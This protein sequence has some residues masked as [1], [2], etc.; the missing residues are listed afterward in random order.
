MDGTELRRRLA[1]HGLSHL[2]R[3]EPEGERASTRSVAN[4]TSFTDSSLTNATTYYYKV[5]AENSNGEGPLSSEASATPTDLVPPAEPLPLVDSFDRANENPLSDAGRWSNGVIGAAETGLHVT[6]NQLAC[7]RTTTCT[8]WRNGAQYGPDAESW[9]RLATLP[10]TSN[11]LR[12]Y[13]R[14]SQAG[15]GGSAYMLRTIQQTGVDQVLLERLNTGTIVTRLTIPQELAAGDTLL[16]RAKGTA[17]EAW[18]H[19]GAG[20]ARLGVVQ[21]STYTA[22]GFAGVGIRGTTGRVDDFGARTMG[23]PP[24]DTEDPSAPGTLSATA[25]S[26]S[27]ID[28]S[29]GV[30]TDNVAVTLYRI[31]RCEGTGCSDFTETATTASTSLADT[32]PLRLDRATPTAC[33]PK[34]PSPISA[35]TRTRRARLRRRR[36]TQ[37]IPAPLRIWPRL[38]SAPARSN[39]S[40]RRPPTT[41]P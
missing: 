25:T 17:I 22:A 14:L 13:V 29:W 12:L 9:A 1:D 18:R 16:L 31:E 24:P 7:T 32:R 40:G 3:H 20:W 6:T 4:V 38:H 19:D 27:Q 26:A 21:D 15:A 41:S 2:S 37:R 39:Y 11:S 10:G 34:T 30:A 28:L 5:S 8:A 33:A 35:R 36:P 23:V